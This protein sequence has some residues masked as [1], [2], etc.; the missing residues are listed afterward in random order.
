M[1]PIARLGDSA[2]GGLHCHGG[3]SHPPLP[4]PGQI[5]EGSGKVFAFGRPVARAGDEGYSPLCCIGLGKI[6]I[7]QNQTKVFADGKP[8][9]IL[10]TPTVHCGMAPGRI[11]TGERRVNVG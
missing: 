7:Q 6:V 3:H 4:T 9:A 8:V 2:Q 10:G 1:P 11:A 5:R